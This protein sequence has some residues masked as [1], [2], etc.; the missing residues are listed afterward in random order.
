ME[1]KEFNKVTTSALA[2]D[3]SASRAYLR[4][5]HKFLCHKA[6]IERRKLILSMKRANGEQTDRLEGAINAMEASLLEQRRHL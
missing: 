2:N 3:L 4:R 6:E 1:K 5:V